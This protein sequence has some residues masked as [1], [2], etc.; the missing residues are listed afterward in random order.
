M[1]E[2]NYPHRCHMCGSLVF[3]TNKIKT[4]HNALKCPCC[5]S[6]GRSTTLTE[7]DLKWFKENRE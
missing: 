3:L 7:I 5:A 1:N 2:I 4:S 6:Y